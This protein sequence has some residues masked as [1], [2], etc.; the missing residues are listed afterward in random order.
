MV[1]KSEIPALT[2]MSR[3][4]T[5]VLTTF[6]VEEAREFCPGHVRSGT[7]SP[8]S[9]IHYARQGVPLAHKTLSSVRLDSVHIS[10]LVC[11][12][13]FSFIIKII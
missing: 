10:F 13:F 6:L 12:E 8:P 4:H 1:L 3:H 2:P 9:L 5:D 7:V 11:Y